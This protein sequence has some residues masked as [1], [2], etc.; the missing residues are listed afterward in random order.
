MHRVLST[1]AGLVLMCANGNPAHAQQVPTAPSTMSVN[2]LEAP[3]G[4][5]DMPEAYQTWS[6]PSNPTMPSYQP[7]ELQT[8]AP[9]PRQPF[10]KIG[11]EAP[12]PEVCDDL[13]RIF[14]TLPKESRTTYASTLQEC[15]EN[16]IR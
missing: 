15:I 13:A 14:F 1:M 9:S 10:A 6:M 7:E 12:D 11:S 2:P 8:V 4:L 5:P 3:V 16:S